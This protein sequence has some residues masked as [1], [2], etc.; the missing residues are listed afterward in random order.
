MDFKKELESY[1]QQLE[2]VKDLFMKIQ[3]KIELCEQL[4]KEKKD[5]K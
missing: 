4:L 5:K 1:K 3:G 2:Q